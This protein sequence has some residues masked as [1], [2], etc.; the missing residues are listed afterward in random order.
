[1]ICRPVAAN[2]IFCRRFALVTDFGIR[3]IE[4][5]YYLFALG[6]P[7]GCLM[8]MLI[9]FIMPM[10]K[11]TA[12]RVYVLAEVCNAWSAMEVFMISVVAALLEI[13]Q[14]AAFI[15]GD[16]CD[17]INAFLEKYFDAP[18]DGDDVCFDVVATLAPDCAYLFT[19]AALNTIVSWSMLRMAH[20]ALDERFEKR[21]GG[22]NGDGEEE[23]KGH[24]VN[25]LK[26]SFLGRLLFVE[27]EGARY[28]RR[29]QE[30]E[31]EGEG[32]GSYASS[33]IK[34]PRAG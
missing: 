32:G 28:R 30:E 15:V 25:M 27:V 19:G 3:W 23:G 14:F 2:P 12:S 8:V 10:K 24:F 11:R 1:M 5:T 33:M 4:I 21:Q 17:P 34:G 7:F 9:L 16:K 29:S 20:S 6:M 22:G 13:Q 18:L 26:G 31:E